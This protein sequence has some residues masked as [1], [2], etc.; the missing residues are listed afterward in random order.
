MLISKITR[1]TKTI[2]TQAEGESTQRNFQGIVEIDNVPYYTIANWS[3]SI[4]IMK[5]NKTVKLPA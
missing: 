5:L 2:S 1:G 3:G 4:A